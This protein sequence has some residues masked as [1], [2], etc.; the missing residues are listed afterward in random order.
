MRLAAEPAHIL[1]VD[2]AHDEGDGGDQLLVVGAGGQ[3]RRQRHCRSGL[4][5][6]VARIDP[7]QRLVADRSK[8]IVLG[9]YRVC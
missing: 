9:I 8:R 3:V 4:I 2:V 5:D 7:D 6:G 1:M